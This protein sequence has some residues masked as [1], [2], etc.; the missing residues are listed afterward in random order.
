MPLEQVRLFNLAGARFC[1]VFAIAAVCVFSQSST[2]GSITGVVTDPARRAVPAAQ[3]RIRSVDTAATQ[4]TTTDSA[5]IYWFARLAPGRYEISAEKAGFKLA[6]REGLVVRVNEVAV[7]DLDLV[8]GTV[9]ET[10]SVRAEAPIVQSQSTEISTLVDDRRVRE[11]PLNGKNFQ[12]LVLL[13][14]GVGGGGTTNQSVNGARPPANSY[15]FDGNTGN[16]ERTPNGIALNGGA[17]TNFDGDAPPNPGPNLISTEAIQEYRVITSNAD[18]TFGR[19]SG[20]QINVI[21]KSGSNEWHGSLYEF[22]RNDKLDARDFFNNGP[23][24]DSQGR[25]VVPPFKQNL[26]GGTL[27]GRLVPDR[28]FIFGSYRQRL[29]QTSAATVPNADLIGLVPGDLGKLYRTYYVERGVVPQSGNPAG[30]FAP[31]PQ[32]QRQMALAGGFPA[33]LFDG[34]AANGEAGTVLLSTAPVRD[35]DQDAFLVRTDHRLTDRL[36]AFVRYAFAQPRQATALGIPNDVSE[37]RQRWQQAVAQVVYSMSPR[38]IAELRGGVQRTRS[39][40]GP[41]GGFDS[42]LAAI[43]VNAPFGLVINATGTG[44]TQLQV[45][46]DANFIDNQT[47]PQVSAIHTWTAARLTLRSGF[48]IRQI[49][50]NLANVSTGR[51]S[52]TFNGFV[53]PT[54]LLGQAA[55]QAQAIA[56]AVAFG[57]AFGVGGGP[58]TPMRGWRSL[59]Q[60]YF[61]QADWRIHPRLTLNLGLR[62]SYFGVYREVNNAISNLF[63][64]DSSG[65]IVPDVSPFTFGRTANRIEPISSDRPMYQ[66]DRNN[67]QPRVGIA[68]DLFGNTATLL[69]AGYGLYHDRIYQIMFTGN[70]S[71]VPFSVGSSAENVPYLLSA[72]APVN[73]L[74]SAPAITTVDPLLRNPRTQRF[75]FAVEQR[76]GAHSSVAAAYVGARSD[77]LVRNSDVNGGPSVPLGQRPDP[78]FGRQRLISNDADS[79][80]DAFQLTA[81]RRF[82]HGVDFTAAY[83]FGR[84]TDNISTEISF[85]ESLPALINLGA[86]PA[87][88]GVQGGGAQFVQR[89]RD[90]DRGRSGFDVRHNLT[91]SHVIELPFGRGRRWLDRAPVAVAALLGGWNLAGILTLRSGAPFTIILGSDV[92]DDGDANTDRPALLSGRLS[93]LYA[94]GGK[95][96]YLLPQAD[97][98]AHLAAPADVTDPFAAIGRNSLRAPSIQQYDLSLLKR[99][100]I[101]ER[102]ALGIEANAFNVFNHANLDVPNANLSSAFFGRISNTVFGNNARQIQLGA[103]LSF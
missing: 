90:A 34:S 51:P 17:A 36:T 33:A 85:G 38:H 76:L 62:Y 29:Q 45:R 54:G 50:S 99:V 16:D 8:V 28:H 82:V 2:V 56:S 30:A 19:G 98:R 65:S 92:N 12:R 47:T 80:Y 41:R 1:V 63:A 87:V 13:A 5:G 55:G 9:I 75:H 70:I 94:S 84:S 20:A 49:Q 101:S 7:T 91:M 43:G 89:P 68:W 57:N 96:Q 6:L 78:R 97:A 102:L 74:G 88:A 93:D 61:T 71:N 67:F 35:L 66:P 40:S 64:V 11:L 25:S 60:D 86:N 81:K 103:R 73:P 46:S 37:S 58:T 52:Y 18:A 31:L 53:G 24:F 59:Q 83:T 22:L 27:G 100:R 14:P 21:T 10:V 4:T 72:A 79:R 44:L 23:F 48:D 69:R 15:S 42:R 32:A 77:D 39:A 95:T 26:F 3:V